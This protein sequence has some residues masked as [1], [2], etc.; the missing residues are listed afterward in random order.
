MCS[1]RLLDIIRFFYS[2]P[3]FLKT[4]IVIGRISMIAFYLDQASKKNQS[5]L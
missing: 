1:A 4:D 2:L 5:K 3:L